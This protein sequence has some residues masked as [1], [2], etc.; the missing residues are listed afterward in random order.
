MT[1]ANQY[2][3]QLAI[4]QANVTNGVAEFVRGGYVT[5]EQGNSF[6]AAV[7]LAP[8]EDE[9]TRTAREEL[10]SFQANVRLAVEQAGLSAAYQGEALRRFGINA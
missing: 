5:R 2:R 4:L 3:D 6:L 7:G 1:T 10:E 8:A 9:E